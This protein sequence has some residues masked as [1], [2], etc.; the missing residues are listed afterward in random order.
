MTIFLL[1]HSTGM[2]GPGDFLEDYLLQKGHTVF[3][4]EHPLDTYNLATTHFYKNKVLIKKFQRRSVSVLNY[5]IDYFFSLTTL[6]F[7]PCD[8]F[9]GANNFDTLV[10]ISAKILIRK[11]IHQI[12]YF[13]SDYSVN[14]FGNPLLNHAYVLIE[15][16]VLKRS[17]RVI[18]NTK[19]AEKERLRLGLVK[20]KSIVI[21]NGVFLNSPRFTK[22]QIHKKWFI[23]IGNVT[24]EHGL[25]EFLR[26][27][28]PLIEKLV[29]IGQGDQWKD[30]EAFC[31]KSHFSSEL[32][33]KKDHEFVIQFLQHFQGFGLAPYTLRSQWT[34]FASPL[35]VNEYIA[36][37]V[38][39]IISSVPEISETVEKG[40]LGITYEIF[41]LETIKKKIQ[42]FDAKDF[43]KKSKKFYGDVNF[44]ALYQ[45]I[46]L[47]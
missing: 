4:L 32:Y 1:T 11:N 15:R 6:L 28:E 43:Y 23:F 40:K 41:D 20:E 42:N 24:K 19:R 18:S 36:T 7:S 29:V 13:A 10:G 25:L 9:I 34:Y 47:Q 46:K 30:L 5:A 3:K 27:L 45:R 17:D 2:K 39:V 12:L 8:V 37:G 31:K 35:K 26:A 14:R 22:K 38:P 21:P 16:I 44:G 33:Y